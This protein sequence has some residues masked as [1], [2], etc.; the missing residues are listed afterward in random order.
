MGAD[1]CRQIAGVLFHGRIAAGRN[2]LVVPTMPRGT[3][4]GEVMAAANEV[5]EELGAA[6]RVRCLRVLCELRL[7]MTI[8]LRGAVDDALV[9]PKPQV[10]AAP[11][12]PPPSSRSRGRAAKQA[13]PAPKVVKKMPPFSGLSDFRAA[14]LGVDGSGAVYWYQDCF[15]TTGSRLYR[16]MP[17][18]TAKKA[19][20]KGTKRNA[21]APVAPP[22]E[23]MAGD[24][25]EL[26]QI[27]EHMARSRN[28]EEKR[29]GTTVRPAPR[30]ARRAVPAQ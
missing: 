8:D 4:K 14:P 19:P 6:D 12:P 20:S 5:Y 22:W 18:S 29:I 16:D 30:A 15:E 28:K 2:P 25:E 3:D 7:E 26:Y 23:M 10:V 11:P 27:G 17:P 21:A 24:A 13:L 1:G 9:P